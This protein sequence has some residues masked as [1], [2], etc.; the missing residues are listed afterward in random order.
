MNVNF[1]LRIY[2]VLAFSTYTAICMAG[3]QI[4]ATRVIF[5]ATQQEATL[6]VRNEG[7]NDIMIGVVAQICSASC[8]LAA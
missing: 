4:G 2:M 3:I 6:Q 8:R 5:P 1:F 7:V